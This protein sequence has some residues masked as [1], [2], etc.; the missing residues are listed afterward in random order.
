MKLI[1]SF[2][3]IMFL[4]TAGCTVRHYE[5]INQELH[6]Y[7]QKPDADEV[8]FFSSID[9]FQPHKVRENDSGDWEAVLPSNIEFKYFFTV[10]GK[11]F[12]PE[13]KFKEQDDFGSENCIYTPLLGIK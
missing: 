9:E 3:S 8:Y 4:L 12:I 5:I 6:L 13:C 10:D 11:L 1:F 7:V 2:L